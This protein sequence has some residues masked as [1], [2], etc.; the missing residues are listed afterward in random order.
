MAKTCFGYINSEANDYE[1]TRS[2]REAISNDQQ[3]DFQSSEAEDQQLVHLLDQS[4]CR[5]SQSLFIVW[6]A[7]PAL[8]VVGSTRPSRVLL[9]VWPA[10]PEGWTPP[11]WY[12]SR[13]TFSFCNPIATSRTKQCNAVPSLSRLLWSRHPAVSPSLVPRRLMVSPSLWINRRRPILHPMNSVPPLLAF[14]L[15]T[16]CKP[17]LPWPI[18]MG[19]RPTSPAR[20][21]ACSPLISS[22]P[23]WGQDHLSRVRA[24]YT[25]Y[26]SFYPSTTSCKNPFLISP[27]T[28]L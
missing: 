1:Y 18:S 4:Y 25:F 21:P 15:S 27:A 17:C 16:A 19:S 2:P 12:F 22:L 3:G 7:T 14:Y 5:R 9:V 20:S 11:C 13:N 10:V 26:Y 23:P 24:F 28:Q 8:A 6:L